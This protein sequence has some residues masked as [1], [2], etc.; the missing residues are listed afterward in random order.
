MKGRNLEQVV[1]RTKRMSVNKNPLV[2]VVIPT[3]KREKSLLGRAVESVLNQTYENIEILIIDDNNPDSEYRKENILFFKKYNDK[4]IRYIRNEQNLG[5]AKS[6]NVGINLACGDYV[7]FLDDDDKYL[8][9]KIEKQLKFML[10]TSCEM[11]FT[12]LKL[13]NTNGELIDYR[14]YKNLDTKDNS[15]LLKYHIMKHL[16]GTPTFMYKTEKIREI[17][18]FDDAKMGQEFYLMFKTIKSNLKICYLDDCDVIAYRHNLGGISFGTNKII[19]EKDL[20]SFKRKHIGTYTFREKMFIWFRH[21]SVM[22]VAHKRNKQYV[23][24]MAYLLIAFVSSPIDFIREG[25]DATQ[26]IYKSRRVEGNE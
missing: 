22:A 13:V 15:K 16:T 19:G 12:N 10:E 24:A 4:S 18:G 3:Y 6:R 8:P 20:F 25:F 11:S 7:T 1:K 14:K 9:K 26:K 5:G 2:S 17:G 23:F 21:F